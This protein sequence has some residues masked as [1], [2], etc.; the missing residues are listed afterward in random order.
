MVSF[1]PLV[2]FGLSVQIV[3]EAKDYNLPIDQTTLLH[4]TPGFKPFTEVNII[5][6]TNST[7]IY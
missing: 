2:K 7:C 1:D 6:L 4:V 5:M 3:C